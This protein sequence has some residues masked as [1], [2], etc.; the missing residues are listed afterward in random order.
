[1]W[2]LI[3]AFC[4]VFF[5]ETEGAEA[6]RELIGLLGSKGEIG[7]QIPRGFG[8]LENRRGKGEGDKKKEEED[9]YTNIEMLLRKGTL[10]QNNSF[11]SDGDEKDKMKNAAEPDFDF[12]LGS[13][14]ESLLYTDYEDES[15]D[16]SS[17]EHDDTHGDGHG[18]SEDN[19]GSQEMGHN[20]HSHFVSERGQEE[21]YGHGHGGK[22]RPDKKKQSPTSSHAAS[23]SM[24][25][26]LISFSSITVISV[27]GLATVGAMPL[28]QGRH[29]ESLLSLLVALAVGTLMGDALMHLLPHSLHTDHGDPAPV[30]RGFVATSTLI[31]LSVLDQVMALF[32]HGH[33]HGRVEESKPLKEFTY[34]S[35]MEEGDSI[36]EKTTLTLSSVGDPPPKYTSHCPSVATSETDQVGDISQE[37]SIPSS[38]RMVL[39]GDAF[40]NFADGLAIGAAFSLGIPAGLSTSIAVLCHELPHEI[41][42]FALLLQSGV[43]TRS[44][45]LANIFSSIAAFAGLVAGLMLGSSGE[46]SSWLLAAT[47]GVFLYVALVS[48]LSE[49]KGTSLAGILLNTLG[50]VGGALLLLGIG[51]YEPQLESFFG[52]EHDH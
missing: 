34:L 48:M 24:A 40:H 44:A 14:F 36:A 31:L 2:S 18:H 32:G 20:S 6:K 8:Q 52:G 25:T 22:D 11:V 30:W 33:S 26:W 16:I 17:H 12:S 43:S 23:V 9:P 46:F 28:L 51:L 47:V 10:Q 3:C 29:R 39:L 15:Q 1:M 41:G 13:W 45:V 7:Q 19:Y 21:R 37:S 50:M 27:V 35:G 4:I 42:D 49:I 5:E 38:A